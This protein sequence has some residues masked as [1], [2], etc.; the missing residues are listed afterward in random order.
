MLPKG[1]PAFVQ[2]GRYGDIIQMLPAFKALSDKHG[3]R[4]L[5]VV[6]RE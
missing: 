2:L 3:K 5:V 1:P 6:S 4:P